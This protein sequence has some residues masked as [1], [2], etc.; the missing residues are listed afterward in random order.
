VEISTP[1]E[2]IHNMVERLG[3]ELEILH[4]E[5]T[6]E[7]A[8]ELFEAKRAFEN[9]FV[10]EKPKIRILKSIETEE[11]LVDYA[12]ANALDLLIVLPRKHNWFELIVKRQ[13]T[14]NIAL[15]ATVPVMLLK[16]D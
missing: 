5:N 3:A 10:A 9:I 2:F 14:N 1:S 6:A 7:P 16:N 8:E 13:H 11:T 4:V 15:H 12:A